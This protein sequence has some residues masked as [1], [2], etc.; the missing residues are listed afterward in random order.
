MT[1]FFKLQ[2]KITEIFNKITVKRKGLPDF[3]KI[4]L[5]IV[6]PDGQKLY[7]ELRNKKTKQLKSID[8][9][10]PVEIEYS[11]Q[12]SEKNDKHYNNIYINKIKNI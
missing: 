10:K 7:P 6:T 5:C 2:G 4:V 8:V 11:F 12:G 1:K 9:S 3:T